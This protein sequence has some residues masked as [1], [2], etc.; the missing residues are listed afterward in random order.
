MAEKDGGPA[1]PGAKKNPSEQFAAL[2]QPEYIPTSGMTLRDYFAASVVQGMLAY[3]GDNLRGSWHSNSTDSHIAAAAYA[4]A[5]AMLKAR[6]A[7]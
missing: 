7:Q 3:P 6:E 4:I 5:D 2:G 1:F